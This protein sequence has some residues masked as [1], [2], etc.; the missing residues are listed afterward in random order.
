MN[1]NDIIDQELIFNEVYKALS[2][3]L[4]KNNY[5]NTNE[6]D[7]KNEILLIVLDKNKEDFIKSKN[8][9]INNIKSE[10]IKKYSNYDEKPLND[11]VK[12]Y[13]SEINSY[14]LLNKDEEF[15]I[16]TRY[17]NGDTSVKN[18]IIERNLRLVISVAKSYAKQGIP[19]LDLIQEGNIGLIKAVERFN[20]DLGYKF[21]TYAIWWIRQCIL[22]S[23]AKKEKVIVIPINVDAKLKKVKRFEAEYFKK[24]GIKPSIKE[25]SEN[26][27]ISEEEISELKSYDFDYTS[28][29]KT[30]NEEEDIEA[31]DLIASDE[32]IDDKIILSSL[33][34]EILNFFRESKLTDDQITILS[35]SFGLT[36]EAP[37]S[38]S[39]ISK[40]VNKTKERVRQIEAKALIKL[41]NS[42]YKSRIINYYD[43]RYDLINPDK[44]ELIKKRHF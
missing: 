36:G 2:P 37:Y 3:F 41:K 26:L 42:P 19:F 23:I 11:S 32:V 4:T 34:D 17:K 29:N 7:L 27:E 5:Y 25:I 40:V 14:K 12:S 39:K 30:I 18:E 43:D 10:I 20:P 38:L 6:E 31:G 21:S 22:K 35:Y 24:N 8:T 44:K 33:S 13:L 15:E 16:F 1:K 9:F 28:M